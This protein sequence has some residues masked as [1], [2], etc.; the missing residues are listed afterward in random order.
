MRLASPLLCN[1]QANIGQ[2]HRATNE[3][4]ALIEGEG[5]KEMTCIDVE[6]R[7][8]DNVRWTMTNVIG[9]EGRGRKRW[10]GGGNLPYEELS[11]RATPLCRSSS[12][13]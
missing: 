4:G 9:V 1:V 11:T 2:A 3:K 13:T 6:D 10:V 7:Q 12:L 5:M 8:R